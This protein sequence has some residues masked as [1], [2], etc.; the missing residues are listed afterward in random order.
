MSFSTLFKYL[1]NLKGL[2]KKN[3]GDKREKEIYFY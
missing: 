2:T 1:I 3:K